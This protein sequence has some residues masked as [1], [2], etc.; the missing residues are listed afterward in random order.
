MES[1]PSSPNKE[2]DKEFGLSLKTELSMKLGQ[3]SPR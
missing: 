1:E 2:K 3:D